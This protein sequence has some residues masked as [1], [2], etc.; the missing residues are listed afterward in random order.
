MKRKVSSVLPILLTAALLIGILPVAVVAADDEFV[1][2]S[3]DHVSAV[4]AADVTGTNVATLAVPAAYPDSTVD[5]ASGLTLTYDTEVYA[6]ASAGFSSGSAAVVDGD[7]VLMTVTYQRTDD[8]TLYHTLYSIYVVREIAPTFTGSIS[9]TVALPDVL[10]FAAEDFTDQYTAHDG[11]EL[12]GI[13]ISGSNPAFGS[14]QWNDASYT[15][16]T[17]VGVDDLQDGAL[18]FAATGV[19][20]VTYT[21]QAYAEGDPE[22]LIGTV[23]LTVTVSENEDAGTVSYETDQNTPLSFS[24]SDFCV[25]CEAKTGETLS[26]VYF[27]LPDDG[28]LY[29][30]YTSADEYDGLVDE[31]T[32]YYRSESPCLS[33]VDFVPAEDFTGPVTLSYTGWSTD[34]TA[35]SGT[36]IITVNEPDENKDNDTHGRA[37]HFSDVGGCQVWAGDAIDYLYDAGIILGNGNGYYNPNASI[38]RGDFI[39]ML[40]RAFQLSADARGNFSDVDEDSY[41]SNAVAVAK[42]LKIAKGQGGKFNPKSSLSRQDAMVFLVRAME[43]SGMELEKGSA[44]DLNAF[45]DGGKVSDYAVEAV[46]TLVNMGVIE[47][48]GGKLNPK[49][50]V[51]RA[52]MAVIL[53]R[54]LTM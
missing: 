53:Y 4:S 16:G 7:P 13:V 14:L 40:C 15:F 1:L 28:I 32:A 10:T 12:D 25:A 31:D 47:G 36:V 54:V 2:T 42:E 21:V 6:L 5:L 26:C 38:S 24:A 41:Y 45:S 29:Y 48:N 43:A 37:G 8:E 9:K 19:G 39:L 30:Q 17:A 11:G 52:E 34:D 44:S 22:T 23:V 51:S 46:A 35:F 18:T 49:A 27:T 33:N 50:N 3:V 20:T